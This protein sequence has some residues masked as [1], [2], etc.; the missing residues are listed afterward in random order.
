MVGFEYNNID[1]D[2]NID[3]DGLTKKTIKSGDKNYFIFNN[4]KKKI[5]YKY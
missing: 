5:Y 2:Y 4:D 3:D 1:L